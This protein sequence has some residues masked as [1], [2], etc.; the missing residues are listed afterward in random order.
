M[1]DAALDGGAGDEN[2]GFVVLLMGAW[3]LPALVLTAIAMIYLSRRLDLLVL[4]VVVGILVNT[5][6]PVALG[7]QPLNTQRIAILALALGVALR[8]SCDGQVPRVG[9][10][11]LMFTLGMVFLGIM[12]IGHG[13]VN[14]GGPADDFL[15]IVFNIFLLNLLVVATDRVPDD[16]LRQLLVTYVPIGVALSV[17]YFLIVY[18]R[19]V[20]EPGVAEVSSFTSVRLRGDEARNLLNAWA[21]TLVLFLPL[22]MRSL[23]DR[24]VS[25]WQKFIAASAAFG[26]V[27][28]LL[29]T[30]SRGPLLALL[31]ASVF[32]CVLFA[33]DHPHWRVGRLGRRIGAIA[34]AVVLLAAIVS[35][36][37]ESVVGSLLVD[38]WRFRAESSLGGDTSFSLRLEAIQQ[39]MRVWAKAPWLG[40][41]SVDTVGMATG[42]E[43]TFLAVLV[44]Y[45]VLGLIAYMTAL[46]AIVVV[47]W[48]RWRMGDRATRF[49]MPA[50]LTMYFILLLTNELYGF[51]AGTLVLA[52]VIANRNGRVFGDAPNVVSERGSRSIWADDSGQLPAAGPMT[53]MV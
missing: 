38:A 47:V 2:D 7:G 37:R 11:Q 52:M 45:G 12:S 9:A 49:V 29:T 22:V 30:F 21:A 14:V 39:A 35:Q 25:G 44:R 36:A 34:M 24:G 10:C 43:N 42:T 33:M 46:W 40:H 27:A 18:G 23:L 48:R 5:D 31:C 51:S 26:L 17:A 19:H 3:F 15:P 28:S 1:T 13:V 32:G 41:G 53:N 50:W 20:A 6:L 16:R 8:L 4:F